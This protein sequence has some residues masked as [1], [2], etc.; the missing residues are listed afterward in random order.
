MLYVVFIGVLMGLANLIPGVSGGT[1]ALLGGLYERFVGSISSVSAFKIRKE[2]VVF[3]IEIVAGI[4]IGILGFSTLID[5]SLSRVPSLMYGIFSGLVIGGTP[6]VFKRIEKFD[7]TSF[8]FLV[9]GGLLVYLVSI[10]GSGPGK[11]AVLNHNAA[12]LLYDV[13]AGFFGAAAM[14]LPGLSGAFILLIMGEYTRAIA[15]LRHFDFVIIVVLGV[16]VIL[17]IV[18]VSRLMKFLMKR[19]RSQT[20]AFLLGLMIGSLP[21]LFMR[22]GSNSNVLQ[23]IIGLV[24]GLAISYLLSMFEKKTE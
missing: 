5:V 16:G 1:I 2:D 15:A 23:I 3:L 8:P 4:V 17:G 20:F 12:S 21:D 6:V 7:S 18:F 10:L 22:P 14:V 9:I 11:E 19:F 13:F 24:S